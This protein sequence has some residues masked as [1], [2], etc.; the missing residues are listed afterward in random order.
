M[1]G[2]GLRDRLHR[3]PL[4]APRRLRG[5]P[6]LRPA[7]TPLSGALERRDRIGTRLARRGRIRTLRHVGLAFDVLD[8]GPLDGEAVVMLHGFPGRASRRRAV[9]EGLHARGMRSWPPIS[10]ATHPGRDPAPGGSYRCRLWSATC[11]RHQPVLR[12]QAPQLEI[13][14]STRTR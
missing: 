9:T 7:A 10:A 2:V 1:R 3:D 8:E 5:G 11:S 12:R 4:I 6:V 13:S 14:Y